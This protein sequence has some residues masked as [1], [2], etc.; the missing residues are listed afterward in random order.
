[1]RLLHIIEG[2]PPRQLLAALVVEGRVPTYDPSP[3]RREG[4]VVQLC[5]VLRELSRLLRLIPG[6]L[7]AGALRRKW[8]GTTAGGSAAC[9]GGSSPGALPRGGLEVGLPEGFAVPEGDCHLKL[10][11][12]PRRAGGFEQVDD[13]RGSLR[14]DLRGRPISDHRD[15]PDPSPESH[16]NEAAVFLE[17]RR[18]DAVA[19]APSMTPRIRRSSVGASRVAGPIEENFR[20][21][22]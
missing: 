6:V 7:R 16:R 1:M 2:R 17:G 4:R 3:R 22:G 21:M 20:E 15:R 19:L 9:A 10:A 8:L 14:G 18:L 12:R 5:S 13:L 11:T